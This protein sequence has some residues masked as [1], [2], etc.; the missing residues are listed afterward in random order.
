[1]HESTQTLCAVGT[2]VLLVVVKKGK[3]PEYLSAE[4][5]LN[6]GKLTKILKQLLK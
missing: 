4:D 1:M 6:Y 5:W 2:A 3:A